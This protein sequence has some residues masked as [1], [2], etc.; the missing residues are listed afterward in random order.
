MTEWIQASSQDEW[1]RLFA[2]SINKKQLV[3]AP[4]ETVYCVCFDPM[5]PELVE[6]ALSVKHRQDRK[7]ISLI[8]GAEKL[9]LLGVTPNSLEEK[10]MEA[11]W[12]GPL[13][14][15]FSDSLAV[16]TAKEPWLREALENIQT[17]LVAATSA[18]LSGDPAPFLSQELHPQILQNC[19]RVFINDDFNPNKNVSTLVRLKEKVEVLR[20]GAVTIPEAFL[21]LRVSS[22]KPTRGE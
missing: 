18:N 10:F 8:L 3:V 2:E 6:R 20:K 5:V 12:P 22:L 1:A 11:F 13:T 14:I 4:C 17:P 9:N 16:R 21:N 19:D 7:F 15:A